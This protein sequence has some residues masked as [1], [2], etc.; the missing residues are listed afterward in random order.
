MTVD[1]KLLGE[2]IKKARYRK[3]VSQ[4]GLS[5]LTDLTPQYLSQ[6]E[7]G[8]K[9]ASL[10]SV[11]KIS[12]ALDITID[13]LVYGC[14]DTDTDDIRSEMTSLLLNTSPYDRT[15]M[16]KSLKSLKEILQQ[17]RPFFNK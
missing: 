10:Q 2:N 14:Y 9:K 7:T 6:I 12:V 1:Y 8:K 4:F 15:V 5:D 11:I 3:G 17:S 16:L 13:E